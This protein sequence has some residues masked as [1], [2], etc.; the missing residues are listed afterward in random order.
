MLEQIPAQSV[1]PALNVRKEF[2]VH[3]SLGHIRIQLLQNVRTVLLGT[4]A[5]RQQVQRYAWLD[6]RRSQTP[7]H[8]NLAMPGHSPTV[9]ALFRVQSVLQDR[10]VTPTQPTQ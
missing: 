7:P 5:L 9:T 8:V 3:A 1:K 10:T 6:I 4:V 2:E